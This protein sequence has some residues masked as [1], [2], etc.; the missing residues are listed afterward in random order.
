MI[1]QCPSCGFSGRVPSYALG[2]PHNA[3]CPK[4]S[5]RFEL[6]ALLLEPEL[7]MP[8]IEGG[9]SLSLEA[10]GGDPGSSVYEL[11][12]IT[13]DFG[14]ASEWDSSEDPWEDFPSTRPL[15]ASERIAPG[16]SR[17]TQASHP[18]VPPL[19]LA[20]LESTPPAGTT[21]PWYSRVLQV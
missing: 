14:T 19:S 21:D 6:R 13:E 17:A 20:N 7:G 2:S 18:A 8:A 1:I 12:A 16:V 3:K 11:K 10:Q 15:E 9:P 5:F 4:C